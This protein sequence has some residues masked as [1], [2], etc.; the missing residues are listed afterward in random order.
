MNAGAKVPHL[1]PRGLAPAQEPHVPVPVPEKPAQELEARAVGAAAEAIEIVSGV[2][3][4]R[5]L[6]LR[7]GQ[8]DPIAQ[9]ARLLS[10]THLHPRS[11]PRRP[12]RN[13]RL[14]VHP[15]AYCLQGLSTSHLDPLRAGQLR[16]GC[17]ES[18]SL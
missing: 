4:P 5:S 11:Q 18:L 7:P 3:G 14:S 2:E 16:W 13:R 17:P 6:G 10:Y 12:P 9:G 8:L 1:V 15:P